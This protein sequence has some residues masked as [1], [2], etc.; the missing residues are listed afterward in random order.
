MNPIRLMIV[1]DLLEVREQ[2]ATAIK[3]SAISEGIELKVVGLASNGNEAIRYAEI[4]KPEV[5][6]MDLEM[7]ELGGLSASTRIKAAHPNICILALTIHDSSA[8]RLA[9]FQAGMDGLICKGAAIQQ[10]LKEVK[11]Q[12][13]K[14]ESFRTILKNNNTDKK[15]G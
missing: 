1:D 10:I 6:L 9:V 2:L 4:Y 5:I 14:Y 11:T 3:L 7:P 12:S 15:K 8:T 13:L